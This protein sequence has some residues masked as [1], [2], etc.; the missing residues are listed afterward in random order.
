MKYNIGDMVIIKSWEEME[1][2]FGLGDGGAIKTRKYTF[3]SDMRD[4]CNNVV[5]IN[6]L[7]KYYYCIE[8]TNRFFTDEMIKKKFDMVTDLLPGDRVKRVI[9]SNWPSHHGELGKIY[10]VLR[11][12]V[13]SHSIS[14]EELKNHSDAKFNAFEFVERPKMEETKENKRL[15]YEVKSQEEF[16]FIIAGAIAIGKEFFGLTSIDKIKKDFLYSDFPYLTLEGNN[17]NGYFHVYGDLISFDEFFKVITKKKPNL[18]IDEYIEAMKQTAKEYIDG[19]HKWNYSFCALCKVTM[20][21]KN[22]KSIK[23]SETCDICP[24]TIMTGKPCTVEEDINPTTR[25]TE[26]MSWIKK[27]EKMKEQK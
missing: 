18:Y 26:L 23:K 1:E 2:E 19:T 14:L 17:I 3:L 11:Y 21:A 8:G 9:G 22:I 4:L 15:N 10:T 13:G 7:S 16:D 5:K 27:Y 6:A 12:D 25:V 20:E 24:W